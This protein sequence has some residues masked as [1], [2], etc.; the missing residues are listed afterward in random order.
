MAIVQKTTCTFPSL[1]NKIADYDFKEEFYG[2]E[3]ND[4]PVNELRFENKMQNIRYL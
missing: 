3:Q 1:K 4:A 2:S